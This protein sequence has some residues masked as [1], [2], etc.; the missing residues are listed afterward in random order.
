MSIHTGLWQKCKKKKK[1]AFNLNRNNTFYS[2]DMIWSTNITDNKLFDP[3]HLCSQSES[4]EVKTVF[5]LVLWHSYYFMENRLFSHIIY[6]NYSFPCLCSSQPP[7]T[8]SMQSYLL[9][10]EKKLLRDDNKHH[11]TKY[12]FTFIPSFIISKR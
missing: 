6:H 8:F 11:Y 1:K 5:S 7:P 12:P 3:W 9:L 4:H 2:E 10:E